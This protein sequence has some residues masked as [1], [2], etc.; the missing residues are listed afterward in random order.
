MGTGLGSHALGL[1]VIDGFVFTKSY[2]LPSKCDA[3]LTSMEVTLEGQ[4][5]APVL[6]SVN[7]M[8]P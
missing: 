2:C 1:R 7:I 4:A 3:K 5:S 6:S 8:Q